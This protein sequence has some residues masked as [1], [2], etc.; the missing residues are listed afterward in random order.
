MKD[1]V[2]VGSLGLL[3]CP[4]GMSESEIVPV[5]ARIGP[6]RQIYSRQTEMLNAFPQLHPRRWHQ[7]WRKCLSLENSALML[8]CSSWDQTMKGCYNEISLMRNKENLEMLCGRRTES[9]IHPFIKLN[10]SVYYMMENLYWFIKALASSSEKL[11]RDLGEN[12]TGGNFLL[13][14]GGGERVFSLYWG[15]LC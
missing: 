13:G 3:L 8:R 10:I 14:A 15:L 12:S 4:L 5:G 11:Y 9:G 7:K 1:T 2:L 6:C